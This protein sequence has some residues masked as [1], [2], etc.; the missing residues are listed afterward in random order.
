MSILGFDDLLRRLKENISH[1]LSNL[2]LRVTVKDGV[3]RFID[4]TIT[5]HKT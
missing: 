5:I 4:P 1:I 3:H 2:V